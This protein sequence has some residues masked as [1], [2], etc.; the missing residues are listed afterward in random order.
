MAKRPHGVLL[1]DKIVMVNGKKI[2]LFMGSDP[3]YLR[4]VCG[5][6]HGDVVSFNYVWGANDA[7][8]IRK[9]AKPTAAEIALQQQ[10]VP[11]RKPKTGDS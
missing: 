2:G 6:E 1:G 5:V 8:D 3:K 10:L 4:E 7:C 11:E 9:A